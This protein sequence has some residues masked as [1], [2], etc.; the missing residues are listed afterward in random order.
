MATTTANNGWAIPTSTDLV[1]DGATAI[2]AL[3]N[4]ID[5]TLGVYA[6]AGLVRLNT[7]ALSAVS[8]QSINNVFSSTY[9]NYLIIFS[10]RTV[11]GATST[12]DLK[13]RVS[14]T[15][16]SAS[17]SNYYTGVNSA[18]GTQ[19]LINNSASAL[20]LT[21]THSS[22]T[23]PY[24]MA[25]FEIINPAIATPTLF[26][27]QSVGLTSAGQYLAYSGGA[28]HDVATAYDGL[29]ISRSSG[30]ITTGAISIYGYR[31]S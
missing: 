18:S 2:A 31:K 28:L 7:T 26:T 19:N 29:T 21:S 3:G 11:T 1:K 14:G 15:D 30:T 5:T 20:T 8:S 25:R 23:T 22:V 12:F 6:G 10:A 4:G 13:L 24:V 27:G 17:Y 9:D 16:S